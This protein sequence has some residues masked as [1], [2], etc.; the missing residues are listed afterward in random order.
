LSLQGPLISLCM[1]VKNEEKNIIRC[2]KSVTNYVDEILVLDT[3]STDRTP[4]LAQRLGAIVN[5]YT[6]ENDFSKARNES[7]KHARGKWILFLDADEEIPQE[8]GQALRELAQRQEAEAYTFSILNYTA[9]DKEAQK[10]IGI[11]LRMFKNNPLYTFE[12]K[13]H[14]Q[15]KPSILK[16]DPAAKIVHSGLTI[17]HYGYCT[18]NENRK[19]KNLRNIML[20]EEAITENPLD[21]F[22]HY[23]LAVSYYV[24]GQ[25]E[26]AKKHFHLA[27]Q[28]VS[29]KAKYLPALFRNYAVCLFDLAQYEDAL[30]LLNEGLAYYPD[31]PD[32]YYLKGQIFTALKLYN[33]A[34]QCFENCL[35]FTN[36]NPEYVS[37]YGV[38]SFLSFEYLADI[39]AYRQNWSKALEYQLLAFETGAKSYTSSQRLAILARQAYKNSSRLYVFLQE[40]LHQLKNEKMLNI[41]FS[42]GCYALVLQELAVKEEKNPKNFLLAAKAHMHLKNWEDAQRYLELIPNNS[43]EYEQA[44]ALGLICRCLQSMDTD[45]WPLI[46]DFT[47]RLLATNEQLNLIYRLM[48]YDNEK[49]LAFYKN[50]LAASNFAVLCSTVGKLAFNSG[51]LD[52]AKNLFLEALS[53]NYR[54]P[55]IYRMVGEIL[56]YSGEKLEGLY[57]IRQAALKEPDKSENYVCLLKHLVDYFTEQLREVINLYPHLRLP[58]HHLCA[59]TTFRARLAGKEVSS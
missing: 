52:L 9:K 48:L 10:Q 6:W 57:F 13:V 7:I 54:S 49:T 12:G 8:T 3:G 20:L 11:N 45:H 27:K 40:K 44:Q 17:V 14:E 42:T 22:S 29:G 1:I 47:D 51:N 38:A 23:N 46:T 5:Y 15:I 19:E 24:S 41:L 28:L 32:L 2:L 21:D 55:A 50:N 30:N 4:E 26:T 56:I 35:K 36:I 31:Y 25:P 43:T 34:Q 39:S 16:A 33:Y 37:T 59:L 53:F 18:D 58:M